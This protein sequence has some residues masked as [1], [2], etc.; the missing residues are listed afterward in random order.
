MAAS[1]A[2]AATAADTS[3][4]AGGEHEVDRLIDSQ[5]NEYVLS[6]PRSG[7]GGPGLTLDPQLVRDLTVLAVAG[8]AAGAAA[9]AVRQPTIIGYFLAGSAVG[10]AGSAW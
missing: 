9:E 8:A 6:K 4:S 7:A 3:A 1:A 5:D 2:A 10:P